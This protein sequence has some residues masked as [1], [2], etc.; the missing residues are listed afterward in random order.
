MGILTVAKHLN[1]SEAEILAIQFLKRDCNATVRVL[2]KTEDGIEYRVEGEK[3]PAGYFG[4]V[5]NEVVPKVIS[6]TVIDIYG[7]IVEQ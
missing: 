1:G 3:I 2:E 4:L 5:F 7:N 6:L